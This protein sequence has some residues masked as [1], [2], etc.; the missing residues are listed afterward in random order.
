VGAALD[1]V[2]M[3][4][5]TSQGEQWNLELRDLHVDTEDPEVKQHGPH[6]FVRFG[7]K[8]KRAKNSKT[9]RVPLFGDGLEAARRW[10][11]LLLV[12]V[13]KKKGE[14][15]N[16]FRLA[17]PTLTGC[18]RGIGAPSRTTYDAKTKKRGKAEL[19]PEWLAAAGVKRELRWHDL[20]HTCASALVSG[21][22]GRRWSL[23]EVCAMLGHSSIV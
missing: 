22:W 4:Y 7:S 6:V 11:E 5:G 16:P 21:M 13:K 9:R 15:R 18:R 14:K 20:R 23:Q 3:G 12:W 2:R 17:F 10:L 1:A 19:L 8:G